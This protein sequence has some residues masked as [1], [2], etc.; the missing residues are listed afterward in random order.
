MTRIAFLLSMLMLPAILTACS[1]NRAGGYTFSQNFDDSIQTI[2]VPIFKNET[3]QRGLEIQ[4]A[5][6]LNKQIKSRTPWTLTDTA[7]A[8]TSLI[9]VITNHNLGQLSRVPGTGLAQEQ[10][11]SI[12]VRF[13]WRDNRSGEILVARSG[14][15]ATATFVPQRQVGE[16]IEEGQRKAID[17]LA[18]DMISELRQ[19][20]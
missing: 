7:R 13:E 6:S 5:E 10:T 2:A 1:S 12:T 11:V 19:S 18:Q 20:W 8:D 14:Y 17:E 4:L 15:T 3:L 16:R 9:G